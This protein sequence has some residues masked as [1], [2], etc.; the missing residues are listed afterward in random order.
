MMQ[1][2]Y[3]DAAIAP[4]NREA[5]LIIIARFT[6]VSQPQARELGA[7]APAAKPFALL[8]LVERDPAFNKGQRET[9]LLT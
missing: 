7:G 4:E 3:A 8:E 9:V 2:L 6:R 1:A 5:L